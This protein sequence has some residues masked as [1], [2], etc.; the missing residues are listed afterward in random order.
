MDFK[1]YTF[2]LFLIEMSQEKSKCVTIETLKVPVNVKTFQQIPESDSNSAI[3][4][5]F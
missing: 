3:Y 1:L 4:H 2:S 5:R